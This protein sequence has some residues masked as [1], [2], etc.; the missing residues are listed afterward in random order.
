MGSRVEVNINDKMVIITIASSMNDFSL[1]LILLDLCL[2]GDVQSCF[3]N[4]LFS[5]LLKLAAEACFKVRKASNQKRGED[6]RTATSFLIRKM[7]HPCIT[8][9]LLKS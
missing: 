2:K 6:L 1:I 3:K 8:T 7:N 4:Y 9:S 5:S